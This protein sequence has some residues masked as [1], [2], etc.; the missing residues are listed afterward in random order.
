VR[1]PAGCDVNPSLEIAS[2]EVADRRTASFATNANDG[3]QLARVD[4]DEPSSEQTLFSRPGLLPPSLP[5][6]VAAVEA[7][8]I[9]LPQPS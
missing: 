3:F 6:R 1:I 4:R 7:L 9:E 8:S 2:V 5:P